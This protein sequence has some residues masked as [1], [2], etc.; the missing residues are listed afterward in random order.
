MTNTLIFNLHRVDAL[1]LET[2]AFCG[3]NLP[4]KWVKT[5]ARASL[6]DDLAVV[7]AISNV[8]NKNSKL[9]K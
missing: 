4:V 7:A 9:K 3:L 6:L 5:I 8:C 1:S 2:K